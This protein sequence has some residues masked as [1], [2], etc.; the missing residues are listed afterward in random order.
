MNITVDTDLRFAHFDFDDIHVI[1]NEELGY[2]NS[3]PV[4]EPAGHYTMNPNALY[5][6][7]TYTLGIKVHGVDLKGKLN[8]YVTEFSHGRV[9]EAPYYNADLNMIIVKVQFHESERPVLDPLSLPDVLW[10]YCNVQLYINDLDVPTTSKNLV[11]IPLSFNVNGATASGESFF[12]SDQAVMVIQPGER[13]FL[14]LTSGA[15]AG[16]GLNL[17]KGENKS[18]G[19]GGDATLCYLEPDTGE[20]KPIVFIEGGL[21]GRLSSQ[22][23]Q[24]FKPRECK[25]RTFAEGNVNQNI[26]IETI[27]RGHHSPI[28]D[29]QLTEGGDPHETL[30]GGSVSAGGKGGYKED[31]GFRGEGGF[32]GG[33][34]VVQI[35]YLPTIEDGAGPFLILHPKTMVNVFTVIEDKDL[36][37]KKTKIPMLGGVGGSSLTQPGEDGQDGKLIVSV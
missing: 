1:V 11:E 8:Q 36:K 7:R 12:N 16:A 22:A 23:H 6:A 9:L 21:G 34:A 5:C 4:K 3:L 20:V 30:L 13:I 37:I 26:F 10:T 24:D 17:I 29:I 31:I 28:N 27:V 25:L 18:G 33:R 35:H 32:S 14:D 15:G 19:N 2:F